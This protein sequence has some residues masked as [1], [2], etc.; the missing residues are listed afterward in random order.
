[1]IFVIFYY[2]HMGAACS[3]N[4]LIGSVVVTLKP[5]DNLK[6][7]SYEFVHKLDLTE[8]MFRRDK[9]KATNKVEAPTLVLSLPQLNDSISQLSIAFSYH[10]TSN[11]DSGRIELTLTR[12]NDVIHTKELWEFK[13]NQENSVKFGCKIAN[14]LVNLSQAGDHYQI[15]IF[16]D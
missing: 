12:N 5:A 8:S 4:K 11:T 10:T 1:M 7:G 6:V 13:P 3:S 2:C 16:L 15:R 9:T 14:P